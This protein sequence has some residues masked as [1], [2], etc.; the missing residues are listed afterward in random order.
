MTS[1]TS[2]QT[3]FEFAKKQ[4]ESHEVEE[5]H[6]IALNSLCDV[7][8]VRMVARGTVNA[9]YSHPRDIFR[10]AISC[11]AVSVIIVHNHPSGDVRPSPEDI[12]LTERLKKAGKL[13]QLPLL[14]H[15]IISGLS[16]FSFA[17]A[18]DLLRSKKMTSSSASSKASH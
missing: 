5:L 7:I 2:S 16:Y 9:C 15:L 8:G 1:L 18:S 13:L 14:D 12:Q 10:F 3:V 6:V 4:F 11:N 17:D